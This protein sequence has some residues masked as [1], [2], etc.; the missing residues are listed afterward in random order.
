MAKYREVT[1]NEGVYGR[2]AEHTDSSAIVLA[3]RDIL[4]SRRGNYPFNP[5]FG[6]NIQKYQFELLD[7]TQLSV[8]KSELNNHIA[9]FLPAFQNVE[10]DVRKVIDNEG[11]E[12]LG[13][14]VSSRINGETTTTSFV[15]YEQ[16]GSLEIVNETN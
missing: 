12:M 2:A 7:A 3:I 16:N 8:I 6:M 11:R 14:A 9:E 5:T 13:I 10:I 1:F 4:L 15:L